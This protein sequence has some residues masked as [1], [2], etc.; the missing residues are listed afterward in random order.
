VGVDSEPFWLRAFHQPIL[1]SRRKK[2]YPGPQLG[3]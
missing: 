1:I 2:A 3:G